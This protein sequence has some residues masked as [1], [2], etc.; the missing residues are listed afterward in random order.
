M[1]IL[2]TINEL[3]L[4]DKLNLFTF[5]FIFP[6][7]TFLSF[8]VS[9]SYFKLWKDLRNNKELSVF[10]PMLIS[11]SFLGAVMGFVLLSNLYVNF[12]LAPFPDGIPQRPISATVLFVFFSWFYLLAYI[13]LKLPIWTLYKRPLPRA[14]I[15][16]I[17]RS[18]TASV[19]FCI[20]LGLFRGI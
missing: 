1:I 12:I 11:V 20:L 5:T 4:L 18:L 16:F 19:V 7:I 10:P 3:S 13:G 17:L 9:Y 8:E 14:I 15:C 2:N 6:S